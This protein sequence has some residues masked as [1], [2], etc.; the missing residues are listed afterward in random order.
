M[1]P[2]LGRYLAFVYRRACWVSL[3]ASCEASVDKFAAPSS[4]ATTERVIKEEGLC[5]WY[6]GVEGASLRLTMVDVEQRLY[7]GT[8]NSLGPDGK[9][10]RKD[11]CFSFACCPHS[12]HPDC[13]VSPMGSPRWQAGQ[14]VPCPRGLVEGRWWIPF[15]QNK[16]PDNER[17][18][19]WKT[20]PQLSL[21]H[22]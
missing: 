9:N 14:L 17:L 13:P 3:G 16:R 19:R 2:A 5:G 10:R 15:T 7:M 21:I 22:I 18:P 11:V 4:R 6:D 12:P 1:E 20:W 8:V